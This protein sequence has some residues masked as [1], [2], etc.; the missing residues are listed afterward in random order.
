[1]RSDDCWFVYV[2]L[3]LFLKPFAP[4]SFLQLLAVFEAFC[5]WVSHFLI[6]FLGRNAVSVFFGHVGSPVFCYP[7]ALHYQTSHPVLRMVHQN[8]K[9][10]CCIYCHKQQAEW[11]LFCFCPMVVDRILNTWLVLTLPETNIFAPEN[12]PSQKET[13]VDG[14][15]P[16]PVDMRDDLNLGWL[17]H[18]VSGHRMPKP[19]KAM[20][21]LKSDTPS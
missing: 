18:Y 15:N 4:H 20:G 6:S 11:N 5:T 14:W 16:A 12:R 21:N 3:W 9:H 7:M 8:S 17:I 1:M 19:C 2:V 10:L 13:T